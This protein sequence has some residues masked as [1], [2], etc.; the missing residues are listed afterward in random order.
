[1]IIPLEVCQLEINKKERNLLILFGWRGRYEKERKKDWTILLG[2]AE[3]FFFGL[4]EGFSKRGITGSGLDNNQ[5][6]SI[7]KKT[8]FVIK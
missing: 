2:S 1:M 4:A 8:L 3:R 7:C 5:L 6:K